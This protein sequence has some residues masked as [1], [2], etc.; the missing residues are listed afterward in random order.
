MHLGVILEVKLGSNPSKRGQIRQKGVKSGRMVEIYQI[1]VCFDW[2][3]SQEFRLNIFQGQLGSSEVKLG[4]NTS[5]RGQIGPDCR[6]I[7]NIRMFR[8]GIF[9]RIKIQYFSRP[10]RVIRG[11]TWVKYVKKGQ[12]GPD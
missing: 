7:S 10:I 5:K 12:I 4:S 1:Y 6:N 3:F 9:S 8:L 11:Q 2:E